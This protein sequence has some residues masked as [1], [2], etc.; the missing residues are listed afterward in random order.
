LHCKVNAARGG[1]GDLDKALAD[2]LAIR[3]QLA[4]VG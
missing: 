4:A 1:M 3:N 2:I